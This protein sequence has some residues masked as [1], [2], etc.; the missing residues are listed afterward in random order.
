MKYDLNFEIDELVKKTTS[1]PKEIEKWLKD[2]TA[3]YIFNNKKS[4]EAICS[5]CGK[6]MRSYTQTHNSEVM[7]RKCKKLAILKENYRGRKKLREEKK[8]TYFV[9]KNKSVFLVI[10]KIIVNFY[11][12]KMFIDDLGTI[13]VIEYFSKNKELH[14]RGAK[15]FY[16]YQKID[17]PKI[18]QESGY[19]YSSNI[20]ELVYTKNLETVFKNTVLEHTFLKTFIEYI[21][22]EDS[23]RLV[24]RDIIL[25]MRNT[26]K[27]QS[28]EMLFKNGFQK[29]AVEKIYEYNLGRHI[30]FKG[31][32]LSK[33]LKLNMYD[34]RKIRDRKFGGK[35]IRIYKE[36]KE[37]A[38]D[39]DLKLVTFYSGASYQFEILK[40]ELIKI[41]EVKLNIYKI[42][43]YCVENKVYLSDYIDYLSQLEEFNVDLSKKSNLY[44]KDFIKIHEEYTKEQSRRRN[45]ERI[46]KEEKNNAKIKENAKKITALAAG[47]KFEIKDLI[48]RSATSA[49]ELYDEGAC[50]HH[51]VGNYSEKQARGD[52]AIL[53]IRKKS[54]PESSYFTAE[55]SKNNKIIQIR[56]IHNCNPGE[57]VKEAIS[58]YCKKYRK[59]EAHG[60]Y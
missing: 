41:N 23:V 3:I 2:K 19:F 36:L 60:Q 51:C 58:I 38:S 11:S 18:I 59:E 12:D 28:L 13:E 5:H 50:L 24:S 47:E 15:R 31:N 20:E 16:N 9:K 49:N 25:F 26:V 8:L 55:V 42:A 56:G 14:I 37:Y 52:C 1:L 46:K 22:K 45:K 10:K 33:I 21:E 32:T 44:P 7:C 27:Y 4:D 53:F 34:I 29:L 6:R 35:E 17:S 40:R 39:F 43:K 30:N 57:D 48:I 54:N